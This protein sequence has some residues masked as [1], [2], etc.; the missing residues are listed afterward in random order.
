MSAEV[1]PVVQRIGAAPRLPQ[2]R[3]PLHVD[4]PA[5][6][7]RAGATEDRAVLQLHGLVLDRPKNPLRQPPG[8][9]PTLADVIRRLQHPPPAAGA[10]ARPCKTASAAR[11]WAETVPGSNRGTRWPPSAPV[12]TSTGA[13]HACPFRWASQMPTSFAPSPRPAKPGG[14][15]AVLRLRDR[16]GVAGRKGRLF[17]DELGT[18]HGGGV[19]VPLYR[20]SPLRPASVARLLDVDVRELDRVAVVLEADRPAGG[21]AGELGVVDDGLAVEDDRQPVPL[22][23]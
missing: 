5:G 14:D 21:E 3:R 15:E 12:A 17:K 18:H 20:V 23:A 11:P 6:V 19:A 2:V 10:R 1:S 4:S 22:R 13:D 8:R 9:R 7:L 16:R